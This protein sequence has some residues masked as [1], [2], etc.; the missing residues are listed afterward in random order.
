MSRRL[1][2]LPGSLFLIGLISISGPTPAGLFENQEQ[3]GERLY[4]ECRYAEAAD[5]FQDS[6]RR[7]VAQYRAG[8]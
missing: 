5:T 4:Q 7:G 6:Y 8:E 2:S 1:R 3:A